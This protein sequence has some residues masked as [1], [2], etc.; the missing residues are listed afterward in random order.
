MNCKETEN[1]NV[2]W[3]IEVGGLAFSNFFKGYEKDII[4]NRIDI[5]KPIAVA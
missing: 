3:N 2:Q 1:T 4:K 5:P